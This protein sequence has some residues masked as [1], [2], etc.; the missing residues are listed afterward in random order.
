MAGVDLADQFNSYYALTKLSY[1]WWK[2]VFMHLL[3]TS[4]TNAYILRRSSE[5]ELLTGSDFHLQLAEQHV[6]G[7]ERRNVMRGRP[8]SSE[9]NP[10]R[11][12][13]RHFLQHC[14]KSKPECV[15]CTKKEGGKSV[16][17]KRTSYRCKTCVPSVALCAVPCFGIY[18]T[19][20]DYR[21]FYEQ[22]L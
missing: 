20:R 11:L 1:K 13:G 6:E 5:A 9:E 21:A 22:Q 2:K 16:N 17:L 4:V 14:G 8:S 19:K 7:C 3:L 18:H 10:L 12:S 15:V